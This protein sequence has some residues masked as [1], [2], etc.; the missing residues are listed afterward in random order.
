MAQPASPPHR[1]NCG[2][3][4]LP[5]TVALVVYLIVVSAGSRIL[6]DPD[7]YSHVAVGQWIIEHAA[8]PH[9]DVFSFSMRGMPWV[10]DEWLSEIL[11]AWIHMHLGWEGLV[12]VTALAFATTLALLARALLRALDPLYVLVTVVAAWG[13]CF[14][15]LSSR[16]HV[17]TLPLLVI[18]TDALVTARQEGRAPTPWLVAIMALWANL[19][20][21]F[22]LGLVLGALFAGEA[23]YDAPSGRAAL[24]VVRGWGIFLVLATLAAC[25]TPNG[26][27]GLLLPVQ[28][29]GMKV[30]MATM[31]EW[32]SPDFQQLQPL[33][34]WLLLALLGML[35]LGLRLPLTRII[36]LLVLLHMALLH[37]RF[38]E[39]LGI[40]GPLLAAPMLAP[41]LPRLAFPAFG[42]KLARFDTRLLRP[43]GT[44]TGAILALALALAAL[45]SGI[46]HDSGR[47]AP[48]AA[49][50]AV[51]RHRITGPVF[52]D[53]NFGSYLI[54]SNIAPFVDG[55]VD[56][57][58][59][60]FLKRYETVG[61]L[62]ALLT[63]YKI[64]WTLL[65]PENPRVALLD[66]LPG[67]RRLY[68][69]DLAIVHVREDAGTAD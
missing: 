39:N 60:G 37:K 64:V 40:V 29:V 41:Q 49:L 32:R 57:Y 66:L 18:W 14:P 42:R 52:N 48:A 69:D 47:F 55:R 50:A 63:Q 31:D 13:L 67:W 28:L 26:I 33:E 2:G 65:E 7:T 16:P 59:D 3:V 58:G 4:S 45:R 61:E 34:F 43:I 36:M 68:A 22:I 1:S 51:A 38:A 20:G 5:L 17:F 30:A 56:V 54:F 15:H 9:N 19:H 44:A 21:G 23:F 53:L 11:I 25:A 35:S 8:V 10:P 12:L 62:P 27:T 46:V 6:D 24:R